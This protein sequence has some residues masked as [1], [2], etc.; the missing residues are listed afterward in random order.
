MATLDEHGDADRLPFMPEMLRFCGGDFTVS[1]RADKTCDTINITGCSR[2][3]SDTVHLEGLRC[4]GSAHGGCQAGCLLFFK[5]EWLERVAPEGVPVN[6]GQRGTGRE[7]ADVTVVSDAGHGA[8]GRAVTDAQAVLAEH[9]MQDDAHYRCQATQLLD[10]SRPRTGMRHWVTDI[11]TR[12]APLPL[13]LK[14]MGIAFLDRYQRFSRHRLPGWAQI[15][16]GEELPVVRG[17]A[18]KPDLVSLD[19]Q[20]G[21]WVEIKS[22][23]QVMDELDT[24][25]RNR[26]LWF[27]REMLRY[28]GQRAQVVK[29]VER[30]IDEKTGRMLT[31]RT[32]S[33][34]LDGVVC[35]GEYHYLCPRKDYA[36]FREAWVRPVRPTVTGEGET[37]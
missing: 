12:N 15:R 8:Q 23:S 36:F 16:G 6:P 7:A 10:A 5:E 35:G 22:R 18:D 28:C 17:R 30:L 33:L 3:M 25:Q 11:R 21:D 14:A 9:T 27:D 24:N 2:E 31:T 37:S 32:P 4:D 34:I 26:G 20:P 13:V 1:A 29:R 19:L